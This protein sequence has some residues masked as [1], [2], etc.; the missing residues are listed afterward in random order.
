MFSDFY[1]NDYPY[2]CGDNINTL[3][4]FEE[5]ENKQSFDNIGLEPNLCI[6]NQKLESSSLI[7]NSNSMSYLEKQ[8]TKWQ[9]LINFNSLKQGL[10]EEDEAYNTIFTFEKIKDFF[11]NKKLDKIYKKL[12][13]N[14][15]IENIEYRLT[16]KK[17]KTETFTKEKQTGEE[18][19]KRGRKIKQGNQNQYRRRKVHNKYSEDNIIKKIKSK[20]FQYPLF[21]LNKILENNKFHTLKKLNYKYINSIKKDNDLKLLNMRLKD[22]YS[23]NIS[24]KFK[25]VTEDYNKNVINSII[26][27][28]KIK[29]Y[30]TIMFAFNLKF[31]DWMDLFSYKKNINDIKENKGIDNINSGIIEN[32]IIGIEHLLS[33]IADNK[34]NDDDFFSIYTLLLYNYKRWFLIKRN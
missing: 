34:D 13:S 5:I 1:E 20:I 8:N 19:K 21:F 7:K 4:N 28:K 16:Y 23:L 15:Y 17:G 3:F 2:F 12:I 14:K 32:N 10:N 6:E 9:T 30:S 29:D 11:A 31:E 22:L 18:Y 25:R 24:P 26:N 33:K 27:N